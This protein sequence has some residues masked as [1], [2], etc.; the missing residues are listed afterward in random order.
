MLKPS[1]AYTHFINPIE[2]FIEV[3]TVNPMLC[4]Y[5][6][7]CDGGATMNYIL[8]YT[9]GHVSSHCVVIVAPLFTLTNLRRPSTV[10]LRQI[11]QRE[12]SV[13]FDSLSYSKS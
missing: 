8:L 10:D 6:A 3:G 12:H 9:I 5:N 1:S 11:D 7:G 13:E 4:T 2:L